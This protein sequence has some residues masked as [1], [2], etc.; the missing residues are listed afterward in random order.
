MNQSFIID[1][2]KTRQDKDDLNNSQ[3]ERKQGDLDPAREIIAV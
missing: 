3:F 1:L 2:P